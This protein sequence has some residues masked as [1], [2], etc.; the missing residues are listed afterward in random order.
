MRIAPYISGAL[1][2]A[3]LLRVVQTIKESQAE[4]NDDA[5]LVFGGGTGSGKTSLMFHTYEA[6]DPEGCTVAQVALTRADFA[7]ALKTAT[8]EPDVTRRF[9]AFDEANVTRRDALT[10]FNKKLI[11]L[12][13]SIRGLRIFHIWCNP[14][15][16]YLEKTFIEERIKGLLV[17]ATKDNDR[18]RIYYYYRKKDLLLLLEKEGDLK[19]RT[20]IKGAKKYAYYRGWFR[21]YKGKL[22][23][24]YQVKKEIRMIEKVDMFYEEFGGEGEWLKRS[25]FCRQVHIS[26][27]TCKKREAA[28]LAQGL[29]SDLDVKRNGNVRYSLKA[30]QVLTEMTLKANQERRKQQTSRLPKG[31]LM[32]G[33][34]PLSINARQKNKTKGATT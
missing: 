20:L 18:P 30:V 9:C 28:A 32:R 29:I 23:D 24:A 21:P 16:E 34:P 13:F 26:D 11:D 25:V 5:L 17:V 3:Y 12:Y 4:K 10:D 8:H 22:W 2:D 31:G 1:H 6:Y 14:S 27:T 15:I 33:T 7:T 19:T